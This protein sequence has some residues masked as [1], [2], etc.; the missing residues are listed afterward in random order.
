M[1][2][3]IKHA[4]AAQTYEQAATLVEQVSRSMM[5]AGRLTA[6]R[7]WLEALPATAF[8][9]HPRLSVYR[10]WIDLVQGK[11]DFT[12]RAMQEK[13]NLLSALPASPENDQLRVELMVILGRLVALSGN[14]SRAIQLAQASLACLPEED[15]ASRARAYSALAIAYGFEGKGE[16]AEPAYQACLRLAQAAGNYSLAAHT[17]M[18]WARGQSVYSRLREAARSYQ[19]IIDLG[20]RSGQAIF[21]P[22]GQGYIGLADIH[23]EWNDLE[24]AEDYVTRGIELC[25]QGGLDGVLTGYTLKARLRQAHGDL[26]GTLEELLALGQSIQGGIDPTGLKRQIQIKLAMGDVDEAARLAMPLMI[27]LDNAAARTRLPLLGLEV[28]EAILIRVLLARGEIERATQ[29]LDRLQSTAEPDKRFGHLIEAYLL[30]ALVVQKQNGG[31]VTSAALE[32]FG[33]ALDLAEPEGYVLLF[34]EEVPAVLPLLK[35]VAAGESH[36][37]GDQQRSVAPDRL[38]A[39]A[40]T[41]LVASAGYGR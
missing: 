30:R 19:S 1:D 14:T 9:C 7:N 29:L 23:L 24:A 40:R 36:R 17:T 37:A 25:S 26:T 31:R 2:E 13:E 16:K 21:F 12:E 10:F 39:Y 8:Q 22:A 5:F 41:L 18:V 27:L 6:L 33:R 11:A 28:I 35:A 34:L 32:Y 15:L 38:Q 3:A 4:L 20:A